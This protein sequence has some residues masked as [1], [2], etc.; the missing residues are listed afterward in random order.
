MSES[1]LQSVTGTF[2]YRL[3]NK[4]YS[5]WYANIVEVSMKNNEVPEEIRN[6]SKKKINVTVTG[7]NLP[8]KTL[9]LSTL[10]TGYTPSTVSS[11]K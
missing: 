3:N 10:V 6:E 9:K 1:I 5:T 7:E 11:S 4:S 2:A 8:V